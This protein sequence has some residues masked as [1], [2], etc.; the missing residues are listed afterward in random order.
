MVMRRLALQARELDC[1]SENGPNLIVVID[2]LTELR[3][4]QTTT[5]LLTA[6]SHRLGVSKQA[7]V[8][9]KH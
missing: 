2:A 1:Y 3:L 9:V 5:T 6:A 8:A 4:S 7:A